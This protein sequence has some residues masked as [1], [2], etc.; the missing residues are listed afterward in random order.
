MLRLVTGVRPTR[1]DRGEEWVGKDQRQRPYYLQRAQAHNLGENEMAQVLID[2][3]SDVVEMEEQL[4]TLKQRFE[5]ADLSKATQQELDELGWS[6]AQLFHRCK[7]R[8]DALLDAGVPLAG[9]R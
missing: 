3:P 9:I 6:Y 2:W 5:A 1:S 7:E 4:A 8:K